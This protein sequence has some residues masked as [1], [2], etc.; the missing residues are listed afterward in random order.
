MRKRQLRHDVIR[1]IIR[2]HNVRTQ[3]D[4]ADQL[5]AAGYDC[6]QATV[7]RDIMDM[8]L[9]KSPEG[10]YVLP[11]E[12]RLQRMVAELV[13]EVRVGGT[14]VVVKTFPGGAQ[15]VCAAF[16]QA[17]LPG[18]LGTVAGD[19]TIMIAAEDVAAADEV[20]QAIE[21]LRR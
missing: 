2:R 9:A 19:D 16:D 1:D 17:E 15:S 4:L 6:T 10:Y 3:R 12:I 7:S 8:G 14:I 5:Q 13:K 11:E 20:R 18:A 21:R